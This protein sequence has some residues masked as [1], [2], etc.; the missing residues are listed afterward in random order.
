MRTSGPRSPS[1]SSVV[2]TGV[3]VVVGAGHGCPVVVLKRLVPSQPGM[4]TPFVA[5]P[6]PGVVGGM[7]M[8]VGCAGADTE[9]VTV[10][11]LLSVEGGVMMAGAG[12]L[13]PPPPP[14]EPPPEL[15]PPPPPPP[16]AEAGAATETLVDSVA[17]SQVSVKLAA[18]PMELMVSVPVNDLV[19]AQPP[20]AVQVLALVDDH[21]RTVEPPVVMALGLAA[22]VTVAVGVTGA[23]VTTMVRDWVAVPQVM[24]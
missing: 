8:V 21:V 1:L 13:P 18:E 5:W 12:A 15:P 23:A 3:K 14:D 16:D 19:P 6:L 20:D 10:T 9:D 11:T 22:I 4:G 2:K 7:T 17:V 24:V